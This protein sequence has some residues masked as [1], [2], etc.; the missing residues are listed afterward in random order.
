M[1]WKKLSEKLVYDGYRKVVRKTFEMPDGTTADFD[2]V[3]NPDVANILAVT[4][5]NKIVI[6]EQFRPGPEKIYAELPGGMVDPGEQPL[7][8][9][10]RELL[11]ETGYDAE[12]TELGSYHR[13]AYI[14]GFSYMFVGVHARRIAEP[15]HEQ[16][17]FGRVRLLSRDE[18]M[19]VV[20]AGVM[21][22][23]TLA[24]VGLR[25][26]GLL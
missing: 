13:G 16:T 14:Q 23:T 10:K 4:D 2:V 24:Y 15:Q 11:E 6:F 26:L 7:E 20:K 25:H 18:F 19:A 8:A 22:D 1:E 21:T 17:E 12:I 3:K 5:D 9:I